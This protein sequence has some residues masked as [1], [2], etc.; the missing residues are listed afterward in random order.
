MVLFLQII[1]V[2]CVA[3]LLISY[4]AYRRC[5]RPENR[6]RKSDA[7]LLRQ[8]RLYTAIMIAAVLIV[9]VATL[10]LRTYM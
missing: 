10:I 2:I 6:Q 4:S 9:V 5:L 8:T 7:Q 1:S 3:A